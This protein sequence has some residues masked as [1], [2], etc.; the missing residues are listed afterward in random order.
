[1]CTQS[2]STVAET[3]R[4]QGT[5]CVCAEVRTFPPPCTSLVYTVSRVRYCGTFVQ[6]RTSSANT[7]VTMR[8]NCTTAVLGSVAIHSS[9]VSIILV[10]P[11][12]VVTCQRIS[13]LS[14]RSSL[15]VVL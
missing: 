13:S 1:M 5:V 4:T 3:R 2:C 14:V 10:E 11:V 12:Q 15:S 8:N 7:C 9:T 6:Y